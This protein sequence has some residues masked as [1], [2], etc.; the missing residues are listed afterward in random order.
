M[1]PRQP[2]AEL[3][4][5]PP[6]RPR[7]SR[8]LV[9]RVGTDA[10]SRGH[11]LH[12]HRAPKRRHC[13]GWGLGPTAIPTARAL[14]SEKL[15][16][17]TAKTPQ[18]LRPQK[19]RRGNEREPRNGPAAPG[20]APVLEGPHWAPAVP[21]LS[22]PRSSAARGPGAAA[23]GR[24]EPQ[25][26]GSASPVPGPVPFRSAP[27]RGVSAEPGRPLHACSRR[28]VGTG[29]S[30]LRSFPPLTE[31]SPSS[32]PHSA[33]AGIG[34]GPGAFRPL[35]YPRLH[36]RVHQ[37]PSLQQPC[38]AP[39]RA[40][41]SPQE[42]PRRDA[43]RLGSARPGLSRGP[44]PSRSPVTCSRTGNAEAGGRGWVALP[45]PSRPASPLPF[46]MR[47]LPRRCAHRGDG[48]TAITSCAGGRVP[49]CR[50][51][52]LGGREREK[53]IREAKRRARRLQLGA[54]LPAAGV[55]PEP[56]R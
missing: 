17:E 12:H 11:S 4:D 51:S 47:A 54:T 8:G 37:I 32:I 6:A 30:R 19:L 34:T 14:T 21:G 38:W 29:P 39:V 2:V 20:A 28:E 22:L 46:G 35:S 36:P 42:P 10:P 41:L 13:R 15:L 48:R 33:A 45:A 7:S 52:H 1:P 24:G 9:P 49:R 5:R 27:P 53:R 43:A 55:V 16:P 25:R 18:R 40:R 50:R 3:T 31:R 44:T 26:L 56:P 23:Q